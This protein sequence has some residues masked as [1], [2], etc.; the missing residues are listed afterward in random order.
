MK[1]FTL[2]LRSIKWIL[3][4]FVVTAAIL[5]VI[6]N[7]K[8]ALNK[9]LEKLL[10]K[11]R[12]DTGNI[13]E[14]AFYHIMHFH[15]PEGTDTF[16]TGLQISEIYNKYKSEAD[17][18]ALNEEVNNLVQSFGVFPTDNRF[19]L[20]FD[21]FMEK[22]QIQILKNNRKLIKNL[23]K[24]RSYYFRRLKELKKTTYYHTPFPPFWGSSTPQYGCFTDIVKI[25]LALNIIDVKAGGKGIKQI[26]SDL[27][28]YHNLLEHS[29]DYSFANRFNHILWLYYE[30][31]DVLISNPETNKLIPADIFTDYTD[32]E[33]SAKRIFP[34][35]V[36]K[37]YTR[38]NNLETW[39]YTY[40]TKNFF[41]M[42]K[43]PGKHNFTSF[44]KSLTS[45]DNAMNNFFYQTLSDCNELLSIKSQG[46]IIDI[47]NMYNQLNS[48]D[49]PAWY[50]SILLRN[51]SLFTDM[52][53]Y[54]D[55][56]HLKL[57]IKRNNIANSEI[58]DYIIS[59]SD[60][61]RNPYTHK[62]M[63]YNAD[64]N[65]VYFTAPVL[66]DIDPKYYTRKVYLD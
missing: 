49:S 40:V 33:M 61:I 29:N 19:L 5:T 4:F 53:G 15:A 21:E 48:S 2:V 42:I 6:Y 3:I 31:I 62:P 13:K 51:Y 28:F 43:K 36:Y 50:A 10:A 1:I 14:N 20:I 46:S 44:W 26:Q 57:L 25:D 35:E 8:P 63:M 45:D 41:E 9:D 65:T 59:V 22:K 55:L 34:T 39:R 58:P 27:K 16:A 17:R 12:K 52:N 11:D 38:I 32:V 60:S 23:Q 24:E 56:L 64:E 18:P 7:C 30:A 66:K 47:E 54:R 37:Q